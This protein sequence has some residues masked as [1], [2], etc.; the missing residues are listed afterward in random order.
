[1]ELSKTCYQVLMFASVAAWLLW[2]PVTSSNDGS[3]FPPAFA[4]EGKEIP[5]DQKHTIHLWVI[6]PPDTASLVLPVVCL[7]KKELLVLGS[8]GP[9]PNGWKINVVFRS[10]NGSVAVAMRAALKL[11][12]E[13]PNV[14]ER[15]FSDG[16]TDLRCA[17]KSNECDVGVFLGSTNNY[18]LDYIASFAT[19][20]NI[21]T[22]STAGRSKTFSDPKYKSLYRLQGDYYQLAQSVLS[23][24]NK[25]NWKIVYLL[26]EDDKKEVCSKAMQA[27][28]DRIDKK[29]VAF[30]GVDSST[31]EYSLKGNC[32]NKIDPQNATSYGADSKTLE[33]SGKG[34]FLKE[35]DLKKVFDNIAENARI[36]FVCILNSSLLEQVAREANNRGSD[37]AFIYLDLGFGT[38]DDYRPWTEK[39][40]DTSRPSPKLVLTSQVP[41]EYSTEYQRARDA[42]G[43]QEEWVQTCSND[44]DKLPSNSQAAAPAS[45]SVDSFY[46]SVWLYVEAL[47]RTLSRQLQ[48]CSNFKEEILVELNRT[49]S[50]NHSCANLKEKILVELNSSYT[51]RLTNRN[52]RVEN[53]TIPTSYF[54]MM[55]NQDASSYET[56]V[57]ISYRNDDNA[58]WD[59]EYNSE[60]YKPPKDKPICGFKGDECLLYYLIGAVIFL[61]CCASCIY[62][63][64][65]RRKRRARRVWQ[66]SLKDLQLSN[67]GDGRKGSSA[68]STTSLVSLACNHFTAEERYKG[69]RVFIKRLPKRR[70]AVSSAMTIELQNLKLLKNDNVVQFMGACFENDLNLMVLELCPRGSLHRMLQQ[71]TQV[72]R[73]DTMKF[74]LLRDLLQGLNFLHKS[75]LKM[76]GNLKSSN[77]VIDSRFVL[78]LSGFGLLS[79][80]NDD[81]QE[82]GESCDR[83]K[84]WR[85]PEVLRSGPGQLSPE[86]A[87]M[88][89]VYSFGII[90]NEIFSCAGTFPTDEDVT[91]SEI[92]RRVEHEDN[93]PFRPLVAEEDIPHPEIVDLIRMCWDQNQKMRPP[94]HYISQTIKQNSKGYS[95]SNVVD[96]LIRRLENYA[97]NLENEVHEQTLSFLEEKRKWEN[98]LH[99][100]LPKSVAQKIINQQNNNRKLDVAES[101]ECVTIYFSDIV[102]F[103]KISASSDPMQIVDLLNELYSLFD[104][105]ISKFDVYK[106]ETIGDAYVVAS[107]LPTKNGMLHLREIARMS[108][109]LL[110]AVRSFKSDALPEQKLEIRIGINSGRCVA[111]VVG[112]N[113]PRYC[114]FGDTVN[115]ASRMESSGEPMKIHVSDSTH[116]LL[117]QHHPQFLLERRGPIAIKGKGTMVTYWLLGEISENR[118]PM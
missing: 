63:L 44:L 49:L 59:F 57:N 48:N 72:V 46:D 6:L 56:V 82:R 74:S 42:Y 115:T 4:Q 51:S 116:S 30:C 50:R 29:K 106:V 99:E 20:F 28:K 39:A 101:F 16:P 79:F 76:H 45:S 105:T 117:Q 85:A 23:I 54:L 104:D 97:Q 103:A 13:N 93:P 32:A 83:G 43:G 67:S 87:Q 88:A 25:W 35:S 102:D 111:G 9:L 58:S 84:L 89:D 81:Y 96:N 8:K 78:K 114:I 47:N 38:P 113:K 11:L 18:E 66:I 71:H 73:D 95:S 77:C 36:V 86:D 7:A 1:M 2:Q 21:P 98:L 108:L 107:G 24:M 31:S 112:E 68:G 17:T 65:W 92:L 26:Y 100:V 41:V 10:S 15:S 19:R 53:R 27:I 70:I 34:G 14:G 91:Y 5:E 55:L 62:A 80:R 69:Q 22:F 12:Y 60:K 37:Y 3:C 52:F 110:D 64:V 118:A 40:V 61:F 75:A 109:A 94:L 33:N 90:M